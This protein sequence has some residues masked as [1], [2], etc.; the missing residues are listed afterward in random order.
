MQYQELGAE[1]NRT[2]GRNY[3]VEK[4]GIE[5]IE[6]IEGTCADTLFVGGLSSGLVPLLVVR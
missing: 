4:E 5:G 2:E 3:G 6:G 1:E